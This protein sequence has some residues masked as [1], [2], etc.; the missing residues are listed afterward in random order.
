MALRNS[1][2]AMTVD[3]SDLASVVEE[4]ST[5]EFLKGNPFTVFCLVG[6]F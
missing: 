3:Y 2:D 4:R 5:L 1:N 6:V